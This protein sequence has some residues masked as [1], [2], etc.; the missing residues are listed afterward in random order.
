MTASGPHTPLQPHAWPGPCARLSDNFTLRQID[1]HLADDIESITAFI[2]ERLDYEVQQ[3]ADT[4][5]NLQRIDEL[6]NAQSALDALLDEPFDQITTADIDAL[7]DPLYQVGQDIKDALDT[8][9]NDFKKTIGG[10]MTHIPV[11][12]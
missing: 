5:A 7:L 11:N 2:N 1:P 3:A 8:L 6:L 12:P 9:I 4:D 10:I